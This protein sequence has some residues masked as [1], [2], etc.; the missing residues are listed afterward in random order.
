MSAALPNAG[1]FQTTRWTQVLAAHGGTQ[2]ARQALRSLCERCYAPVELFI[3]RHG[4]PDEARDLTH[5]FFARLLE[6]DSLGNPD[7]QRGR[8]RSYLL[9][10]VKHF[11]ADR[12]DHEQALRRGGGHIPQSLS[13]M[14]CAAADGEEA[15]AD[16]SFDR[17]WALSVVESSIEDLRQEARATAETERFEI[18][19]QWLMPNAEVNAAQLATL[20]LSDGARTVAIHRLRK[21]FREV[22]RGRIA[23]TVSDPADVGDEL[24]H[25]IAALRT[26]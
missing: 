14:A 6:R 17:Q 3:A 8:F 4:N 23:D 24:N 10:A 1:G 25:L 21:R 11:L 16:A 26:E 22:V 9:G 13:D 19:K 12:R 18:L 20:G 2:E 5:E 7:P 15:R